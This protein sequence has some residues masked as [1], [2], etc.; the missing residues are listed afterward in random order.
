MEHIKKALERAR[1]QKPGRLG[2]P[3]DRSALRESAPTHDLDSPIIYTQTRVEKVPQKVL[4]KSRI[5][6]AESSASA[7]TAYKM[8]RTQV[9]NR[10]KQHGWTTLGT[11]CAVPGE[12]KSL[13][14]LNLA[15]SLAKE[16]HY[17]V[18]LVDLDF[19]HP[20]IHTYLGYRPE[21]GIGDYL[22]NDVPIEKILIHPGVERLVILPGKD[23]IPN[24]SELLSSRKMGKLLRELKS[25][26]PARLILFDLPPVLY[27]DDVL[28][29]LPHVEALLLVIEEGGVK[30]DQVAKMRHLLR[31]ANVIG[32]VLNKSRDP[33]ASYEYQ[34]PR[35]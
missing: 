12:G 26:Y 11:T 14:S 9:L 35:R 4:M 2:K 23:P 3:G 10:M 7:V 18:L 6:S 17:T 19:I 22:L 15:I 31:D 33:S 30:R 1:Q 29:L 5:L 16:L 20:K 24:S 27:T 21:Y 34:K 25:R 8:L 28:V 32:T 13:T